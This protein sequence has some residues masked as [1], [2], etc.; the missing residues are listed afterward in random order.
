MAIHITAACRPAIV[1]PHNIARIRRNLTTGG[2]EQ[3]IQP[4]VPVSV[5]VEIRY[6]ASTTSE[7][8]ATTADSTKHGGLTA[9][10]IDGTYN[11]RGKKIK[12][13]SSML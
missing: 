11:H 4:F 2:T 1:H 3:C 6:S 10:L 5:T 9:T 7:T 8:H 13:A 12:K